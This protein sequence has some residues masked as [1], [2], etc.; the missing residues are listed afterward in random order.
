MSTELV[1]TSHI[2]YSDVERMAMAI[3]KSGIFGLKTP[4]QALAL[5]LVAQA[6]GRHPAMAARDF[7]IIQGRPALKAKAKLAR[8]QQAGGVIRWEKREN[9]E[10]A[11]TFSHPQAPVPISI[12]WSMDDAKRA[13]LAEKETWQRYPRQML[14]A[15]VISEGV[16]ATYPDAGG[17]MY[18]PEEVVDFEPAEVVLTNVKPAPPKN[19]GA[20]EPVVVLDEQ[21]APPAPTKPKKDLR[22]EVR[23]ML[24]DMTGSVEAAQAK[25][26]DL[27]RWTNKDGKQ[28]DGYVSVTA[29]SERAVPVVYDKVKKAYQAW[30]AGN[31]PISDDVPY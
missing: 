23:H 29:I 18:V 16:D 19:N 10:C 12:R 26:R 4:E 21:P 11:A 28:M 7:D 6:E 8:F 31:E 13:G 3:A 17:L 27:T 1:T 15:R 9:D 5:M 2:P 20:K 22:T 30:K 24:T 25:L 14:A